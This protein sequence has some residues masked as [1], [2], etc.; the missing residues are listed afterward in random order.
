M[1]LF[2]GEQFLHYGFDPGQVGRNSGV[3]HRV[4]ARTRLVLAVD[5]DQSDR[6]VGWEHVDDGASS[7]TLWSK[8]IH[9]I[10]F[11]QA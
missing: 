7:V 10:E 3:G 4:S 1:L 2:L 11:K 9:S 6:H 5:A 8:I